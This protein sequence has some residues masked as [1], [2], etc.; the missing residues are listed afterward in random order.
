MTINRYST[1]RVIIY[2]L[3][4]YDL[5]EKFSVPLLNYLKIV[6]FDYSVFYDCSITI[7]RIQQY[8]ILIT[9]AVSFT[10]TD[11][12]IFLPKTTSFA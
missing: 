5:A 9:F 2:Q 10:L 7:L 6:Y 1:H 4:N 8:T 11:S 12:S 3:L